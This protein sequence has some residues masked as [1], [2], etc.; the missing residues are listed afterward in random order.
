MV[1]DRF[2]LSPAQVLHLIDQVVEVELV[3]ASGAQKCRL[4]LR[5]KRE[6]LVVKGVNG[7]DER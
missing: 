6:V 3:E 2:A 4:T 1:L 5:P 7:R